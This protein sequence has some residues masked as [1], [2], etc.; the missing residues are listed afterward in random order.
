[1]GFFR[2]FVF[3]TPAFCSYFNPD[4]TDCKKP[5]L[6]SFCM[7]IEIVLQK[8][9]PNVSTDGSFLSNSR[10]INIGSALNRPFYFAE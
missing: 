2:T 5:V 8:K 10:I 7:T 4:L 6:T 9:Y 3:S 1:M